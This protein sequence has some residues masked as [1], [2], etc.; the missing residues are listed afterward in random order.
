LRAALGTAQATVG[1]SQGEAPGVDGAIYFSS[2]APVGSFVDVE[3]RGATS[4]DFY[5]ELVTAAVG[6]PA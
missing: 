1:R 6:V 4:F 3:L 2:D 5:G